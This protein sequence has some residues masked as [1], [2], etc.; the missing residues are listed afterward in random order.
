MNRTPNEMQQ[1]AIDAWWD[2]GDRR[3]VSV[4]GGWGV[5]KTALIPMIMQ[6]QAEREPGVNGLIVTR[7]AEVS[8]AFEEC[9]ATLIGEAGWSLNGAVWTDPTGKTNVEF[10]SHYHPSGRF[11]DIGWIIIEECNRID[12]CHTAAVLLDRI[13]YA[14]TPRLMLLGKPARDPWW[15]RWAIDNGG[16]SIVAPSTMNRD[17][18]PDFDTWVSH[19]PPETYRDNIMCG[20]V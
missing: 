11:F 16:V 1:Q 15:P 2:D 13:R 3:I 5:G 4:V 20:T 18:L 17:N 9:D 12:I 10:V 19:M 8:S 6:Q 7:S 14:K